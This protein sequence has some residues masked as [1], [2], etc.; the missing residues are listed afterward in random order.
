MTTQVDNKSIEWN[1]VCAQPQGTN[2]QSWTEL[3]NVVEMTVMDIAKV[4]TCVLCAHLPTTTS[5][6]WWWQG[7]DDD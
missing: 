4:L 6:L 1:I 7:C 5:I 3:E 2:T